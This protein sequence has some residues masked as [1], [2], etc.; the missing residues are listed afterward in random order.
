MVKGL[1]SK[2][3][4]AILMAVTPVSL[5]AQMITERGPG[6][7]ETARGGAVQQGLG[8]E[9]RFT[10]PLGGDGSAPAGARLPRIEFNA[11]PTLLFGGDTVQP[12]SVQGGLM[13]LRLTPGHSSQLRLAGQN[14]TT[15]YGPLAADDEREESKK[16]GGI[17]SDIAWVALVAG[18][19]MVT[20]IG[21]YALSCGSGDDSLC[22]SD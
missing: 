7:F 14:V 12:R 22:G 18:G 11:G 6:K 4:I 3:L 19:V 1:A 10:V 5:S 20:L 21:V 15:T 8:A 9:L 17:G 16:G 2:G 13:N